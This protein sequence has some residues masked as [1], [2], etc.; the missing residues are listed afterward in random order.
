MNKFNATISVTVSVDTIANNLLEQINPEFKH[1]E[2]VVEGIIG[3]MLSQDRAA[4]SRLYNSLN[5]YIDD[6]NFKV[7]DVIIP[8]DLMVHG[9]WDEDRGIRRIS[10]KHVGRATVVEV[11]KYG[12]CTLKVAF[13]VPEKD[14]ILGINTEWIEHSK[15]KM[16]V[17]ASEPQTG[18]MTMEQLKRAAFLAADDLH[19][20]ETM[21]DD[22]P[23]GSEATSKEI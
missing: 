7:G 17:P 20:L 13:A 5:G 21:Y 11:N 8:E 15:C 3:R 2:L 9:Y 18:E 12:N 4:L 19:K 14:G 6:I 1:R 10:R 23:V 22:D 16:L